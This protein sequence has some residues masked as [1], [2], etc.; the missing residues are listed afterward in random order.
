MIQKSNDAYLQLH[1]HTHT[2]VDRNSQSFVS[3]DRGDCSFCASPLDDTS[4]VS[5]MKNEVLFMTF[6][7]LQRLAGGGR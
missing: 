2:T 6:K 4:S 3:N 5:R 7:G 1:T